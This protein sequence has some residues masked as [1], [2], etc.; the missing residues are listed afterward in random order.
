MNLTPSNR[1][2]FAIFDALDEL[3][4]ENPHRFYL[5]GRESEFGRRVLKKMRAVLTPDD[6][7][8]R[9]SSSS[10]DPIWINRCRTRLGIFKGRRVESAGHK[11]GWRISLWGMDWVRRMRERFVGEQYVDLCRF[12]K[13]VSEQLRSEG[14]AAFR[15]MT[16]DEIIRKCGW[17]LEP[18]TFRDYDVWSAFQQGAPDF[19][20]FREGGL[21]LS[22]APDAAGRQV[23]RITMRLDRIGEGVDLKQSQ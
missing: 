13:R 20:P 15:T 18:R 5:A 2:D 9:Y 19:R 4:A 17:D 8:G 22:F 3:W 6:L 16:V 7:Q 11:Q 1:Y 21:V 14:P 23:E 12:A 10:T